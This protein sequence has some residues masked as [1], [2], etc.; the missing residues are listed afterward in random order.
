M[1]IFSHAEDPYARYLTGTLRRRGVGVW[2]PEH[3]DEVAWSVDPLGEADPLL[4]DVTTGQVWGSSDLLGIWFQSYPRLLSAEARVARSQAY[5]DAEI[6]ASI[7]C[8]REFVRCRTVGMPPIDQPIVGTGIRSR[9]ELRTLGLPALVDYLLPAGAAGE[10]A[11]TWLHRWDMPSGWASERSLHVAPARPACWGATTMDDLRVLVVV[12]IGD[13]IQ[14]Y[15]V[16]DSKVEPILDSDLEDLTEVS[17]Q[18]CMLSG[19]ALGVTSFARQAGGWKLS[20]HSLQ[21]PYWLFGS[22]RDVFGAP[23]LRSLEIDG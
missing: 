12:R 17:T 22:L 1:V 19:S 18:L 20:R 11:T 3:L 16:N 9:V 4:I 21:L 2:H 5:V 7:A 6:A 15:G 14:C 8:L 10:S 13:L 23:L